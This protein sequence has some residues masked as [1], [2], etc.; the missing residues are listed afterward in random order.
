M[1]YPKGKD[2]KE[3][4]ASNSSGCDER[5][6]V[7]HAPRL[8]PRAEPCFSR[9]ATYCDDPPVVNPAP[10]EPVEEPEPDTP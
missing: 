7:P 4:C 10:D 3:S 9:L 8:L 1:K 2:K 5:E 6:P